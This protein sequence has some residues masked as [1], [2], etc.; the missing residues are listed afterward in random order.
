MIVFST[1]VLYSLASSV[2]LGK[3]CLKVL[4]CASIILVNGDPFLVMIACLVRLQNFSSTASGVFIKS[5]AKALLF[6][7]L[8]LLVNLSNVLLINFSTNV[9]WIVWKVD[10]TRLPNVFKGSL[11]LNLD[12]I[13]SMN[14]WYSSILAA[15]SF[16]ISAIGLIC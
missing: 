5:F 2:Y 12:L 10:V 6:V 8:L 15:K 7:L 13:F 4:S 1:S 3:F 14:T 9:D 11:S 16:C